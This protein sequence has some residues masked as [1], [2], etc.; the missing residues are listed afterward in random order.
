M[1][2]GSFA[3]V[4]R[5]LGDPLGRSGFSSWMVFVGVVCSGAEN[6]LV[7]V[8]ALG[9]LRCVETGELV[10][11]KYS[12]AWLYTVLLVTSPCTFQSEPSS[13]EV[14]SLSLPNQYISHAHTAPAGT[15][16]VLSF[17]AVGSGWGC[18]GHRTGVL[19]SNSE[20]LRDGL[21]DPFSHP[22][23]QQPNFAGYFMSCP[24]L[25]LSFLGPSSRVKLCIQLYWHN[26]LIH[27][28]FAFFFLPAG[29]I[30]SFRT[31]D[32]PRSSQGRDSIEGF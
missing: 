19:P 29:F 25:T 21:H 32:K 15:S 17:R 11:S 6:N 12:A 4:G 16:W 30:R 18:L 28:S 23:L 27:S 24:M 20:H 26:K 5:P 2:M 31:R 7:I 3:Q 10:G 9:K 22:N 1:V 8:P 14:S 13:G